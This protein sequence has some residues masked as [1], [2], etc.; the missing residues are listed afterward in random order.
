MTRIRNP[1]DFWSGVLFL[2]LGGA[3]VLLASRYPFGSTFKMGPGYFP[4]V[5]GALLALV[6]LVGMMRSTVRTGPALE[7]FHWRKLLIILGGVLLFGF[8]WDSEG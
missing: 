2:L 1:R 4:T 5:L 6:G 3:A 8:I 7:A